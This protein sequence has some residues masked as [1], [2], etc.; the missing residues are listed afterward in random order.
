[1]ILALLDRPLAHCICLFELILHPLE[2]ATTRV[3]IELSVQQH[4]FLGVRM[5][6]D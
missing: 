2:L 5:Q 3:K 4:R 6:A 1:M